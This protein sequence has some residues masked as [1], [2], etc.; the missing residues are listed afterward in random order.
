MRLSTSDLG[1]GCLGGG[2]GR[3]TVTLGVLSRLSREEERDRSRGLG[4]GRAE[5]EDV[6]AVESPVVAVLGAG[7]GLRYHLRKM[8]LAAGP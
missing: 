2:G 1:T 8:T 3:T 6:A 4:G 5:E 7:V